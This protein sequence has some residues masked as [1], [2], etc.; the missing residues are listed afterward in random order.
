MERD[1]KLKKKMRE[2]IVGQTAITTT[3]ESKAGKGTG[4]KPLSGAGEAPRFTQVCLRDSRGG[5]M[6]VVE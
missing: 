6:V 1:R 2:I 4:V 3:Q 5:R